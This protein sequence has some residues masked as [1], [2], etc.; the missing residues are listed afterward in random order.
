MTI[1]SKVDRLPQAFGASKLCVPPE[2]DIQNGWIV[3]RW[4]E[5]LGSVIG[6][7]VVAEGLLD[8]FCK[9]ESAHDALIFAKTFGPLGIC[10][11][12]NPI[13]HADTPGGGLLYDPEQGK[14][15]GVPAVSP[16]TPERF[17]CS[18]AR[19]SDDGRLGE[20]VEWWL[21]LA[22]AMRACLK[23]S[24]SLQKARRPNAKDLGVINKILIHE[25]EPLPITRQLLPE[26]QLA[27]EAAQYG[28][29][30]PVLPEVFGSRVDGFRSRA[31]EL[32]FHLIN[33]WLIACPVRLY[34]T[35]TDSRPVDF[36]MSFIAG[37]QRGCFPALVFEL[38]GR[39]RAAKG[40]WMV[41]C[42]HCPHLVSPR[43]EPRPG[44]RVFCD[45]CRAEGWPLRYAL[46]DYYA[47]KR[48]KIL[49]QRKRER[50]GR[51]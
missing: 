7:E 26:E 28:G 11:H 23:V 1:K 18:P 10:S 41:N 3:W 21:K 37:D 2:I 20:R 9:I 19:R 16:P 45:Q 42:A 40:N 44:Q 25:L 12:G 38:V 13:C 51:K 32:V 24:T 17:Y 46:R 34:F 6:L 5:Y 33:E 8:R 36:S 29:D 22:A 39:I 15:S 50:R 49:A 47:R 30:G 14:A 4:R 31:W 35:Y 48:K 43:R 27:E